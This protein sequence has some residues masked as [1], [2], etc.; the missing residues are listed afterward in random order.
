VHR[1]WQHRLAEHLKTCGYKV[2]I[3]APIGDGKAIDIV[4]ERDGKRIAFEIETG[5]SDTAA[6][7]K[8][9]LSSGVDM[10]FV[11]ATSPQIIDKLTSIFPKQP[12]IRLLTGSEAI[13]QK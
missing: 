7:V 8:K 13:G 1:Y 6:N 3:E 9:C 4:A 10:V 11:V 5:T 12:Q 2:E